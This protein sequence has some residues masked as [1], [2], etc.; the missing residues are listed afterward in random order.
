MNNKK[1]IKIYEDY[2]EIIDHGKLGSDDL[3]S[4]LGMGIFLTKHTFGKTKRLPDMDE[5]ENYFIT[6]MKT[7]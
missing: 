3:K 7:K 1:L 5:Q 2:T 6:K 4:S